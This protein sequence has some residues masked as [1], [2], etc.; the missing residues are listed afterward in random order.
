MK[1]VVYRN[2]EKKDYNRIKELINNAFGFSE[3]IKDSN[4]LE[5]ILNTRMSFR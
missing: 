2:L 5:S 4:L 3:F 1:N